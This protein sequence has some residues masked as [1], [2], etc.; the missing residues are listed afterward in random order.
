MN[1]CWKFGIDPIKHFSVNWEKPISF[2]QSRPA[3]VQN[4]LFCTEAG[5]DWQNEIGFSQIEQK[6]LVIAQ[7]VDQ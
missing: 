6:N 3:S 1:K 4:R 7:S 5:L 2:C